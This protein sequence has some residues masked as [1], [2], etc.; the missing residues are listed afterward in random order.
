M[1]G[2]KCITDAKI[3]REWLESV[4]FGKYNAV[5]QQLVEKCLIPGTTLSNWI[6]GKCRIPMAAKRDINEISMLVSGREIFTVVKPKNNSK[7]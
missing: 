4:P 2:N 5:K 1:R 3:L 6:Y 7:A